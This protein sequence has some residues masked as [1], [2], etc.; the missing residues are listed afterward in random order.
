MHAFP[1]LW[2][3]PDPRWD[4]KAWLEIIIDKKLWKWYLEDCNPDLSGMGL[5]E[6]TYTNAMGEA[7]EARDYVCDL[8]PE[9]RSRVCQSA[10]ALA[11]HK[12]CAHRTATPEK[13][14][15]LASMEPTQCPVCNAQFTCL[16]KAAA[17]MRDTRCRVQLGFR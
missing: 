4:W 2:F 15:L 16:G 14:L 11:S 3:M 13:A 17:H 5:A 10:A 1:R 7:H 9:E 6:P 8:C 12:R